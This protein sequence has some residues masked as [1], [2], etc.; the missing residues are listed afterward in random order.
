VEHGLGNQR[1]GQG[2]AVACFACLPV[3][4]AATGA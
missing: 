2:L 3:Y 1:G 4:A